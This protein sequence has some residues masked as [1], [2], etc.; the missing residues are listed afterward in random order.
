VLSDAQPR[1]AE[2]IDAQRY[3]LALRWTALEPD[4]GNVIASLAANRATDVDSLREAFSAFVAPMQNVLMADTQ[5]RIAYKAA[6]RVPLRS[7]DNDIMGMTPSPGWDTRYDW[8]GYLPYDQTP[9]DDGRKG[10]IATANQRIHGPD[11]PHFLTQDWAPPYRQQRIEQLLLATPQHDAASFR[12]IHGDLHAQATLRLLPFLQR[13]PSQHALASAAQ[14]A[15]SG[16]DGVMRADHAAPL[17]F[18]AW[19]DEFTRGVIGRRLGKARFESLYGKR[20]FRSAVEGILERDDKAWC[21]AEGC[22]AA[23]TAALDRA[24]DKIAQAQGQDVSQWQWGEAHPALSVHRPLSNIK[25]LAPLVEVRT[26]TGGDP[27]TVNVGQYHLDKADAPYANR[28]AASLRAIY[29]LSNLDNSRFIYQ[30]GQSGHPLSGRYRDMAGEW[31][32]VEYRPLS[33]NPGQG[34]STLTL[35]P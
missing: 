10:W 32:S 12:A 1:Q 16:F 15:L 13:T 33:M 5:G 20:N 21:G 6:G 23:S 24:L 7:A 28:H 34:I 11:Y 2:L 30:T 14:K 35:K 18:T 25:A 3:A 22:G 27:F 8:T 26:P 31:E 4:G 19:I 17:I 9:Q 29:D